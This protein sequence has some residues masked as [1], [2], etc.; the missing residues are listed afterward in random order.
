ILQETE[1]I[2][3]FRALFD[4]QIPSYWQ[5]HYYP[6]KKTKKTQLRQISRTILNLLAI[7]FMVPLSYAYGRFTDKPQWQEKCF[8]LLQ[9]I[10][11]ENNRIIQKSTS[12]HWTALNAFDSQGMIGLY[13]NYC[14]KKKCL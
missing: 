12:H 10:A 4:F 7:N 2:K 1:D 14:L 5:F 13:N 3:S 6:G 9:E 8:D 11:P